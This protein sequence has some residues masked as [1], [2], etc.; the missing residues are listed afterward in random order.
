MDNIKTREERLSALR[1][2][3]S[4]PVL[5]VG[6]GINGISTFRELALQGIPAI[7]VE[8]GDWCQAASGALS[9][10]IHGGLRYLETGEFTLVKESVTERDRLLKNASH[11]VFPLRTTVPIDNLA[12]GLVNATRRF[13]RLSDK[14]TRRGALL[15]KTGLSLYDIYTRQYGSM[16]KHQVRN[17]AA[18]RDRWPGFAPWVKY[19]AS[20]YDAWISA[21]ERL[22]FELIDD[23][24]KACPEALALNY[25]QLVSAEG[26]TVILQ[27]ALSGERFSLQP[28]VLVN[29]GGAWIDQ[30]NQRITSSRDLPKL[31][32]GTKGSHLILDHPELLHM[33]DGEMVYFENQEGRVCIMFPWFGK[34]LVG[35][36]DIRVDDPDAVVCEEEEKDYI[37]E[38][39]R[40][41]FPHIEVADSA[42]VYTFCGVRPLPA[43]EA[44]L[45][46]QIS[47]NHSLV[48]LPA[49]ANRAWSTL[50]LVGGKWTTFRQFGEEAAD[51]VLRLL[52]EK[53]HVSSGDVPIGGGR[54]FPKPSGQTAWLAQLAQ[55]YGV[56]LP[57]VMQL[58]KRYGSRAVPLLALIQQHGEQMLQHHAAYSDVELRYLIEHEQVCQLEDLLVRRTSLAI[59][60]ELSAPLVQEIAEIMAAALGWSDSERAQQLQRGCA[61]LARLHGLTGLYPTVFQE[62]TRHVSNQ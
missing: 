53:R 12:G 22:G 41:V 28:H 19:S 33:L 61:N 18:T 9:R 62:E 8:K 4:T 45:N 1:L 46:G 29:A 31:I 2:R 36:T 59:C 23:A 25:L 50:C 43:S 11:Y 60:G 26:E 47:R 42:I 54:D 20:Y 7:L 55:R 38:S 32:G 51:R 3:S 15:I 44:K 49:D 52:G 16:P 14:P 13:L 27:D 57:R 34:V 21:P 5:I 56:P 6:G 30:V 39:L 48:V 37:L 10:M 58:A 35:S 40:F 17:E 24:E